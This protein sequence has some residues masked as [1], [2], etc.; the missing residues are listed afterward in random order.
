MPA[1]H[2]VVRVLEAIAPTR[3]AG[4]W[5]NVG[6][7]VEGGR[8]VSRAHLCIDLTAAVL[9]E[10]LDTGAELIVSYHPPIFGGLKRLTRRD[11]MQA[12]ILRAIREGV[13]IY[14]PH[15]ALDAAPGGM[16]DWL[17]DSLAQGEPREALEPDGLLEG[18]GLGRKAQLTTPLPLPAALDMIKAH[19]G[20][21]SLRVAGDR[22]HIRSLA[23][24]PGAGGS[25][26]SP[27][28][29]VD[30]LLTGEWRHHDVLAAVARGQVVVLTDHS[31]TERG[32]LPQLAL[33]LSH[34][35]DITCAVS[36]VD[37]DPLRIV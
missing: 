9:H 25:V 37:A 36:L 15:T 6:L 5:D 21:G 18:A 20:L 16:G 8:E 14:S 32:F 28:T 35:A 13:S 3:L 17:V 30:L 27:V 24:C 10:A 23:C 12:V 19:L 7:L 22:G 31:N 1:L 11:P 26:L 33:R 34:E 2:D 4:S 29:D